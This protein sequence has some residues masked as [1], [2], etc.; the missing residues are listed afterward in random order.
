MR[1]M[2][3]LAA[4]VIVLIGSPV[5]TAAQDPLARPV[6]IVHGA[7][8]GGWDWK[9]V[10]TELRARDRVVYRPTLTGLGERNHLASPDIGLATHVT[11]VVN[12]I[13]WEQLEDLI[14]VGH[15]YGG[16]VI[17]GVAEQV[18]ERIG[19]PIKR[20]KASKY[21]RGSGAGNAQHSTELFA[22][23]A[24][25]A[26]ELFEAFNSCDL[27]RMGNIFAKDLEFYHDISGVT[28]YAQTMESSKANCDKNL[29]L[30]R[31]L[32]HG[33][34]EVYP[35][36][37]DGAIQIGQHTFCHLEDGEDDCGPF[38]FVHV[39]RRVEE[40]WRLARVISYGH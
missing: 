26:A 34:L 33:S 20:Q 25:A 6:V 40:G 13:V 21:T 4:T 1:Y 9:S 22:D 15:S 7:W 8:G 18:A 27:E 39:W 36:G 31:E 35:I 24:R 37:D 5:P 12:L 29:G 2:T 30:R 19:F 28:D 38:Q 16:M 17:T 10:E 23:I 11:D 32:V 3:L 14:L